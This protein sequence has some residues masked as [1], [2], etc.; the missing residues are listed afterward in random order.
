MGNMGYMSPEAIEGSNYSSATDVFS[1]GCVLAEIL[2][3]R[4]RPPPVVTGRGVG[5]PTPK[6]LARQDMAASI[7]LPLADPRDPPGQGQRFV[8]ESLQEICLDMLENNP[9]DRP[10]ALNVLKRP[11]LQPWTRAFES[12]HPE[13]AAAARNPPG[14]VRLK[15]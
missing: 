6:D 12:E 4:P 1:L 2:S 15:A 3:L 9:A 13:V 8:V 10:S 14:S 11:F 5:E 7:T